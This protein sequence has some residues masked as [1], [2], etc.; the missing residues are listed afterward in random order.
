MHSLSSH[1]KSKSWPYVLT[2]YLY[3]PLGIDCWII[4]KVF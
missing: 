2:P 1:I 4:V 3:N